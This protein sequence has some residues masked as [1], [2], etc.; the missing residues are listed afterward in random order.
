MTNGDRDARI[1]LLEAE[2]DGLKTQVKDLLHQTIQLGFVVAV[3]LREGKCALPALNAPQARRVGQVA[4]NLEHVARRHEAAQVL[5]TALKNTGEDPNDHAA[6]WQIQTARLDKRTTRNFRSKARGQVQRNHPRTSQTAA[7]LIMP[8]RDK[9]HDQILQM[10]Y[11][12]ALAGNNDGF[13]SWEV[14]RVI[15]PARATATG[16]SRLGELR[17]EYEKPYYGEWLRIREGATRPTNTGVQA[18]VNEL[19]IFGRQRLGLL[20]DPEAPTGPPPEAGPRP[21]EQTSLL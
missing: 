1:A 11:N 15:A 20:V 18:D 19:T 5:A 3:M 16:T 10:F 17:G 2:V 12:Q 21:P 4:W 9:Q 14:G 7:D 6:Q 8:T 13:T